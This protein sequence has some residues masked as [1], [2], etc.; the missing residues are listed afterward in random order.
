MWYIKDEPIRDEHELYD[1]LYS[2]IE[3][4][5]VCVDDYIDEMYP[6]SN[7]FGVDFYSSDIIHRVDPYLYDA[8]SDELKEEWI[9][10]TLYEINRYELSDGVTVA[11]IL[12][13]SVFEELQE[14][15]WRDEGDEND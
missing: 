8:I 6:P 11:E 1:V 14:I 3:V 10:D 4:D 12:G 7:M 5:G 15:V 9:K 13:Y 2:I